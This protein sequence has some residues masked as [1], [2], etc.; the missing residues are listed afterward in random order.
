MRVVLC[1]TMQHATFFTALHKILCPRPNWRSSSASTL[2]TKIWSSHHNQSESKPTSKLNCLS[3][4]S[5]GPQ[6]ANRFRKNIGKD[7]R[8][9]A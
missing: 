2:H 9:L 4:A 1:C 8:R 7:S 5:L 6:L 3:I